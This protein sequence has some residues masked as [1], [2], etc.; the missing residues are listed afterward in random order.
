[1]PVCLSVCLNG[2]CN[3]ILGFT[4]IIAFMICIMSF[5]F[6]RS[7]SED[8]LSTRMSSRVYTDQLVL[9]RL[10]SRLV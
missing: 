9:P 5:L 6:Y 2:A 7:G 3:C 1:M 8:L 4:V 10:A